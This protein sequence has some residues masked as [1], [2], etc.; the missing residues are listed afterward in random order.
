MER[1]NEEIQRKNAE[2]Q[3][4][5]REAIGERLTEGPLQ[6]KEHIRVKSKKR[7][8][9]QGEV[10]AEKKRFS[11]AG[12]LKLGG[13]SNTGDY[14]IGNIRQYIVT[15]GESYL[16]P[17]IYKW[18]NMEAA[19]N[20]AVKAGDARK[21]ERLRAGI[22]PVTI[23]LKGHSRGAVAT[24]EGAMMLKKWIHD[25]YSGIANILDL[26]QLI[27]FDIIQYDPVPGTGSAF[28]K[29][30]EIDVQADSRQ[31]KMMALGSSAETTVIYSLHT[32]H[33]WW[34]TPQQVKN[35][36]R[37]ILTP[38]KHGVGLDQVD[39]TQEAKH[40]GAITEESTGEVYRSSGLSELA[41]GVYIVDE[42]NTLI[43]L[44][45]GTSA[46]AIIDKVLKRTSWTQRNRHAAIK[47]VVAAWFEQHERGKRK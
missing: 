11:I 4:A 46:N 9:E 41:E 20:K 47:S 23:L 2:A 18:A 3:A 33:P 45:D 31:D 21:A 32:D 1:D 10:T 8:N 14:S 37:I 16:S 35:T 19:A 7:T 24:I 39:D 43:K 27:K 5:L 28:G 12:P 44:R 26:N 36:K 29:N 40:R 25:T 30:A 38:F 17:L 15:L 13:A 6:N 42:N 22:H 34:F